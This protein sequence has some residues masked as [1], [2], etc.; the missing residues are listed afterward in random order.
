MITPEELDIRVNKL[1]EQVDEIVASRKACQLRQ[2]F[3]WNAIGWIL[4]GTMSA[5]PFIIQLQSAKREIKYLERE[6]SH[7]KTMQK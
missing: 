6:I 2:A 7:L 5:I 4:I 3:Y 1:K